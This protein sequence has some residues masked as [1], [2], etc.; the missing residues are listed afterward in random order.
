[1]LLLNDPSIIYS[2]ANGK[3]DENWDKEKLGRILLNKCFNY[4]D[5]EETKE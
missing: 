3:L 1:M 5:K 4:F 2:V